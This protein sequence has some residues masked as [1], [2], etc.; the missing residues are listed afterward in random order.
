MHNMFEGEHHCCACLANVPHDG[1]EA[2]GCEWCDQNVVMA[3]DGKTITLSP[4]WAAAAGVEVD[5]TFPP[6][7]LTKES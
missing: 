6:F 7:I 2:S 3:T 1:F 5:P 4:S